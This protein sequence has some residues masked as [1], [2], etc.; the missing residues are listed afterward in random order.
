MRAAVAE[1]PNTPPRALKTLAKDED[2]FVINYVAENPNTPLEVLD[3]LVQAEDETDGRSI[4]RAVALNPSTGVDLLLSVLRKLAVVGDRGPENQ[5]ED[6]GEEIEFSLGALLEQISKFREEAQQEL[7]AL[8]DKG[9]ETQSK[10]GEVD[11]LNLVYDYM[12]ELDPIVISTSS[13]DP[14]L[15]GIIE[16]YMGSTEYFEEDEEYDEEEREY[17]EARWYMLEQI[18]M[19]VINEELIYEE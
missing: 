14:T 5:D 1:N 4:Y 13:Y 7:K 6:T 16:D 11:A 3:S 9:E 12:A 10:Q 15:K 19:A 2:N 18:L 17:F 8:E